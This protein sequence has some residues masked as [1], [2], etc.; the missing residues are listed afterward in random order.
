MKVIAFTGMP[1]AGKSEAV[2]I[3]KQNDIL[4]VRMGDLIWEETEKRGLSL[5]SKNVGF[6]ADEMRK[7]HG[8]DIWAKKTVEKI[9][10]LC[11]RP[12]MLV[13][14][15]LRT[16][17]ELEFFKKNLEADFLVVAIT[18]SNQTRLTRFLARN[19]SDDSSEESEFVARDEREKSW[20]LVEAIK[21]AD[22]SI[23][24]E[25]GFDEFKQKIIALFKSI[26]S[27]EQ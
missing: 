5:D 8:N 19:R 4:V 18:A 21:K 25:A 2:V 22:I 17:R 11:P 27:N 16:P 23:E 14:D 7:I 26:L 3:A 10:S 15:G 24:N 6:V 1:C 13:I 12:E 20:G 9:N